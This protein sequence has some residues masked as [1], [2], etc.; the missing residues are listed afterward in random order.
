MKRSRK[1]TD[2]KRPTQKLIVR[3][4][5]TKPKPKASVSFKSADWYASAARSFGLSLGEGATPREIARLRNRAREPHHS[6]VG[7]VPLD[8]SQVPSKRGID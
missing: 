3:R 8:G 5:K 1:V 6:G 7:Q 4:Q 2:V